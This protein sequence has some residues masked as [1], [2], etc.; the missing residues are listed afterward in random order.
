[1]K[2]ITSI[3]IKNSRRQEKQETIKEKILSVIAF[4]IVFLSLAITMIVTSIYVTK[5]LAII[6]QEYTFVNILLLMNFI[7]LFGKSIFET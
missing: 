3:I 4:L 5:E 2:K 1:M 7:I 6:N